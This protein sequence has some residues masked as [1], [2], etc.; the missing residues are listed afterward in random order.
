MVQ[1][2]ASYWV[3]SS[4]ST[5]FLNIS[6]NN[7]PIKKGLIYQTSPFPGLLDGHIFHLDITV[8]VSKSSTNILFSLFF[9]VISCKIER[10]HTGP[11][12]IKL[13]SCSTQL[14]TKFIQLTIVKMP[15]IVGILT[16]ISMINTTPERL[17]ARN[18]FICWYSNFYEQLKFLAQ[19]S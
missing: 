12:V 10:N 2:E 15:T 3:S 19:L 14:S 17:T 7:F 5:L 1:L 13:F 11:E 6:V 8:S 16:F 4:G 9:E 18:F